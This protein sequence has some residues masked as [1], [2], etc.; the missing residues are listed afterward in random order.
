MLVVTRKKDEKLVIGNE[1]EIQIIKISKDSVR[2]GVKAPANVS[3][4][5]FEVYESILAA[6]L[7]AA[8]ASQSKK[9]RLGDL[10]KQIEAPVSD[11]P[12]Q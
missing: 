7:A 12:S 5:R 10:A 1:V 8:Q 9:K 3:V 4:H 2:I 11:D 6:N